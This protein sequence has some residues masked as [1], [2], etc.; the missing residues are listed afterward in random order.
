MKYPSPKEIFQLI[1]LTTLNATDTLIEVKALADF[2]KAQSQRGFSVAAVCVHSYFALSLSAELENTGIKSA[3]VAGAFPHGQ[4][5]L[6]IKTMEIERAAEEG[7]DEIDI[8]INRGLLLSNKIHL[9]EAEL[10][11]MRLAAGTKCLKTIIESGELQTEENIR[12]AS[13]TALVCGADFIKT[14]TG[15]SSIGATPEAVKIMCE[16][17]LDFHESTGE[18]RGIK[19]S[20]GVKTYDDA[21]LY[22][23]IVHDILG[24][25]WLNKDL[26]RIGAS[27]LAHEL[28]KM[29][30]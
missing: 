27:S 10:K 2:A 1:D 26:F 11:E 20:G 29:E 19:V 7:V 22:Y 16:E 9:L 30:S 6:D 3:V 24:E 21:A 12:L 28:L 8:V 13:K 18:K 5:L 4:T 15:K 14:S 23:N 25:S 17:I